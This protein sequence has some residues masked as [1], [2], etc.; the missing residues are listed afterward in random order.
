MCVYFVTVLGEL[1][2]C[3]A[4]NHKHLSHHLSSGVLS[5]LGRKWR[6]LAGPIVTWGTSNEPWWKRYSLAYPAQDLLYA[7]QAPR[8]KPW[9]L[10]QVVEAIRATDLPFNE[11]RVTYET[12]EYCLD[13]ITPKGEREPRRTVVYR[14]WL[15]AP[16]PTLYRALSTSAQRPDLQPLDRLA[17]WL[18]CIQTSE[19]RLFGADYDKAVPFRKRVE[20]ACSSLAALLEHPPSGETRS[21]LA[22]IANSINLNP[23]VPAC[24]RLA[25]EVADRIPDAATT[26]GPIVDSIE[27]LQ[28]YGYDICATT[29][30]PPPGSV[31]V[32]S[33]HSTGDITPEPVTPEPVTPEPA[34]PGPGPTSTNAPQLTKPG[35][36]ARKLVKIRTPNQEPATSRGR[37]RRRHTL[38]SP[39][40]PSDPGKHHGSHIQGL[41]RSPSPQEA[42]RIADEGDAAEDAL[43]AAEAL[44]SDIAPG[45]NAENETRAY[46]IRLRAAV[47]HVLM[48][49]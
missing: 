5:S 9:H 7:L 39:A 46:A 48:P 15:D 36:L 35:C 24:L 40:V 29:F 22:A 13:C 41:L 3:S 44:I 45:R 25:R 11:I 43:P 17:V 6:V 21:D 27:L 14:R 8:T 10:R 1:K 31:S 26:F 37:H 28:E 2:S 32:D 47:R 38:R 49:M 34:N 42:K 20:A 12:L 33:A 23:D 4:T 18:A 19:N 30:P 16:N